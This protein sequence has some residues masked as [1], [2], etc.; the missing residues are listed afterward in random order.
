MACT[1]PSFSGGY[2]YTLPP[3]PAPAPLFGAPTS[4]I[5]SRRNIPSFRTN[6]G[7]G[8]GWLFRVENMQYL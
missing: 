1:L 7:N 8:V 3:T 5:L 4:A 2:M 6:W